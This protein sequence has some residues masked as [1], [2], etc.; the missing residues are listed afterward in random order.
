MPLVELP[1]AAASDRSADARRRPPAS[2]GRRGTAERQRPEPPASRGE[3]RR[4]VPQASPAGVCCAAHAARPPAA[5]SGRAA[6]RCPRMSALRAS[7]GAVG[8]ACARVPRR[9]AALPAAALPFLERSPR[10]PQLV[11]AAAGAPRSVAI[12]PGDGGDH[13]GG[14]TDTARRSGSRA[15]AAGSGPARACTA[16]RGAPEVRDA[17]PAPR[18]RAA[19][20][21]ASRAVELGGGALPRRLRACRS[22]SSLIWRSTSSRRR[23]PSSVRASD[24]RRSASCV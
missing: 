9:R 18:P 15:A 24:A 2:R 3:R 10:L 1:A 14:L 4:Q 7:D 23:S 12:A 21:P 22:S 11:D 6:G 20:V 16:R 13:A 8:A 5:R 19:A 17:P